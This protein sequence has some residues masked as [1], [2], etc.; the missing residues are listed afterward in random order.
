MKIW[1][2]CGEAMKS[3]PE[4]GAAVMAL[5]EKVTMRYLD[6]KD[7]KTL[8][9]LLKKDGLPIALLADGVKTA[10]VGGPEMAGAFPGSRHGACACHGQ[11]GGQAVFG[12]G[13][14]VPEG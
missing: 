3:L 10:G 4:S 6:L 5:A 7:K 12:T 13:A 1:S 14:S 9:P 11:D 8:R 2:R